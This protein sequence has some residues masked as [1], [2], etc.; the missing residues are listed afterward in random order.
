MSENNKN[1]FCRSCGEKL[2]TSFG[3]PAESVCT[4][5]RERFLADH[6]N[7]DLRPCPFCGADKEHLRHALFTPFFYGAEGVRVVCRS[8]GAASGY[9]SITQKTSW[10]C[11]TPPLFN[12]D[13]IEVGFVEANE[14]WNRR[15]AE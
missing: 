13:T 6:E 14:K 5:C 10:D 15:G 8:C 7:D 12:H 1:H 3:S 4:E 9:G 2:K 11:S